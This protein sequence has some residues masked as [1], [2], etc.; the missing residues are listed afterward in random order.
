MSKPLKEKDMTNCH[1]I[2]RVLE[3]RGFVPATALKL[4]NSHRLNLGEI[5]MKLERIHIEWPHFQQLC[6]SCGYDDQRIKAKIQ[7]IVEQHGKL[8]NPFSRSGGSL[9]GTIDEI[10]DVN[11]T[12]NDLSVGTRVCYLAPLNSVPIYIENITEID[13]IYGQILCSGYAILFEQEQILEIPPDLGSAYSLAIMSE[14][15]SLYAAQNL[16]SLHQNK[17][18]IILGRDMPTALIYAAA[19]HQNSNTDYEITCVMDKTSD[20]GL[21]T[22]KIQEFLKPYVRKTYFLDIHDPTSAL[23]ILLEDSMLHNVD[24]IILAEDIPGADTL[25]VLLVKPKG[26]VYFTSAET[27]YSDAQ[28]VANSLSKS[29]NLYAYTESICDFSHFII[30]MIRHIQFDL[31]EIEQLFK[32]HRIESLTKGRLTHN[33]SIPSNGHDNSF[34]YQSPVTKNLVDEVLNIA[35]FDCNVIIQGETGVGKEKVLSLIHHHSSRA[36]KPCIKINCATI[37]ENLAESEFFGYES[38]AFTGAQASGKIGYFELANN[39]IL[40]LDEIG[41]LSLNMQSKL[42]RVLQENQFYRVGGTQQINVDVRVVCANNVPLYDIVKNGEFREDLYYRLNICQINVPPLRE[43]KEDILCL[44]ESFVDN[45]TKKYKIEKELTEGALRTLYNYSWPGNVR[46][47]ENV[48]QRLIISSKNVRINAADVDAIINETFYN[49]QSASIIENLEDTAS[50]DYHHFMEE[51]ERK[52]IEYALKKEG[53]TRKAAELI[54]LPQ[55][56]FA[57]KKLKHGL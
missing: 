43:R 32:Q 26:D 16:A 9:L 40:F 46:E 53:T 38:G 47:L 7:G 45:C 42:L 56:T 17:N 18:I 25:A 35:K 27:H 2:E 39:G 29:V 33:I 50:L 34:V 24:Q 22:E 52:I 15:D 6:R 30:E 31:R 51:Q 37:H 28:S 5:R 54:G 21:S 55:T 36:N 20:S 48:I 11:H 4:N 57:R 41:S 13:Y 8:Y 19:L 3:P 14:G 23:K 12:K 44:S 49:E 1:G 10:A